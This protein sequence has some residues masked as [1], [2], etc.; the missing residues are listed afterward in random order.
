MFKAR[1]RPARS[2]AAMAAPEAAAEEPGTPTG[3]TQK[4]RGV[5][6]QYVYALVFSHPKQETVARLNL[7]TPAD[8]SKTSFRTLVLQCHAAH[9]VDL[10]ETACFQELHENGAPHLNLLVRASAQFRWLKPA[11]ELRRHGVRVDYAQHIQSWADGVT[12]FQVASEHKPWAGL[13]HNPEQ[14]VKEGQPVPLQEYLPKRW[15][16]EGFVRTTRLS[17]L[18]FFDLCQKHELFTTDQL[19]AK[20]TELSAAG[21]RGLLAYLL[22]NDGE[23]QFTKVLKAA[24]AKERVRRAGL[25]REALL[26]EFVQKR[27][28]SCETEGLCYALMKDLLQR[29]NLDGQLQYDVLGALRAGRLKKRNVCLVGDANCGKSFLFK[30]LAEV[31]ATYQRPEGGTHQLEELLGKELVLLNDFEYDEAAKAWMPWQ[32]FKNF[33]EGCSVSV[34]V[35]KSRGGNQ[36]FKGTAPVLLTAPQEVTL[37]RYGKEVVSEKRQMDSRVLYHYLTYS[38]P[39]EDRKEVARCCGHC[40]ARLYL[41]GKTAPAALQATSGPAESGAEPAPKRRRTVAE[42][43]GKLKELKELLDCGA[44]CE[45]EFA[46]L[47]AKLLRGE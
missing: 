24:S 26:E 28:C 1:S 20:A 4:G 30:G 13:D 45:A 35:P 37:K 41:E 22:D 8:F 16:Q 25:T 23:A 47:K 33:L 46:D 3:P 34:A 7:K 40:T 18:S 11:E 31:F 38:I 12:Y 9:G 36:D 27:A 21:D 5:H 17:H 14:W 32:Y 39:D 42:C 29:N 43:V 2:R 10:V 19:W 15:R 44:L 6:G